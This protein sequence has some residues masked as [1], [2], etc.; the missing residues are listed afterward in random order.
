MEEVRGLVD[1]D[2]GEALGQ[3]FVAKTFSPAT[4]TKTVEMTKYVEEAM[5]DEIQKLDWM[6]AATKKRAL[7]KLGRS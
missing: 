6:S 2:L 3:V 1:R 5:A 7:E 4:K